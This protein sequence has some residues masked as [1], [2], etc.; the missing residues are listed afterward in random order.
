MLCWHARCCPEP[1]YCS[2]AACFIGNVVEDSF[3]SAMYIYKRALIPFYA[4]SGLRPLSECT[5]FGKVSGAHVLLQECP[6]TN[7]TF[8][9][10]QRRASD[11]WCA[12]ALTFAEGPEVRL[13]GCH[14]AQISDFRIRAKTLSPKLLNPPGLAASMNRRGLLAYP[15][16]D[17]HWLVCGALAS[18]SPGSLRMRQCWC[19]CA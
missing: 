9:D 14:A 12:E 3:N 11:S 18:L 5:C 15:E 2:L 17:S 10:R 19:P 8:G 6:D 7:G 13:A 4:A 1:S 16:S